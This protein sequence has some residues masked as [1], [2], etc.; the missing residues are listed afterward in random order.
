MFK[1]NRRRSR[2]A[3]EK[4]R[5]SPPK[6]NRRHNNSVQR[7][8][9]RGLVATIRT[10]ISSRTDRLRRL[11]G[12]LAR[13]LLFAIIV[14][15]AVAGGRLIERHVRTSKSFATQVITLKGTRRLGR[16]E[17]LR[18]AGLAIGKNVFEVSPKTA[19][20]NLLNHPW[21]ASAEVVRRLPGTYRVTISERQAVALL[22]MGDL[23]LVADDGTVF[24]PLT[25]GDPFDLPIITGVDRETFTSDRE[26]RI[27]I[28]SDLVAMLDDYARVGLK[29][30]EKLAEIHLESDR[31]VSFYIGSDATHVRLGRPPYL[32]KLRRL[33]KVLDSLE[34]KKSRAYYVYLDNVRRPDRVTVKLR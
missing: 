34:K 20:R 15:S 1:I 5:E 19:Q 26:F 25:D 22:S 10:A 17:V 24:K 2:A 30:R 29:R 28:I 13:L 18:Q 21:I 8:S 31:G 23:Y 3:I 9:S 12:V 7:H 32:G 27:S 33:K 6:V 11:G 16:D 14:A 4:K